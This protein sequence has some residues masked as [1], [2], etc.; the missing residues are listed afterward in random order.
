MTR[1]EEIPMTIA[2]TF[3]ITRKTDGRVEVVQENLEGANQMVKTID[4]KVQ[5][6][7]E[8]IQSVKD[9]LHGVGD[10]VNLVIES[11]YTCLA[12]RLYLNPLLSRR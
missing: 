1:L 2:E 5:G 8:N 4:L 11:G 6:I 12:S 10:N 9:G 3:M 7:G